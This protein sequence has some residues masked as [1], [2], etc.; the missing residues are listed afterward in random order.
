MN[1]VFEYKQSL[2]ALKFTPE[3]KAAL[4]AQAVQAATQTKYR[5][6]VWRTTIIAAALATAL[7]VGAGAT[8]VLQ[9]AADA[10]APILGATAAQTEVIDKIGRPIGASATDNGITITADAII[11]DEYNACIIYT[12]SREDGT[13]LLPEGIAANQLL[14]GGFCG[15]SWGRGGSHGTAYF[16]DSD[17][18]D[19]TLQ[20][21][22][23]VS[24]DVPISHGTAKAE[25]ENLSYLDND[26]G[27]AVP[28]FEGR[29]KFRF[30]V[31]YEDTSVL[32]G[33]RETFAQDGMTFTIDQVSI[34]PVAVR[35]A[36][37]VDSEVQWSNAASGKESDQ[38]S[39][40]TKRYLENVEILLTKTDGTVLDLSNSGGSIHPENGK[41]VCTKS[42]VLDEII[43]IEDISSVCVGGIIYPITADSTK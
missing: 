39:R 16:I 14:L 38:D 26:T 28:L 41:T 17:P 35:V 34:S 27:K 10:F 29:W 9:S 13:A 12:I 20:Y 5:R 21:V 43:P 40:E 19:H 31:N 22:E 11:G 32:M 7:L 42:N 4:S 8:G 33:N 1:E 23:T 15:A 30:D 24:S 6:P 3:Q 2:D 18:T 25:L 36:Y 37:T